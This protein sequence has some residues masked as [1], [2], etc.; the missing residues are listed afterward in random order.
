MKLNKAL[1]EGIVRY[2]HAASHSPPAVG[3]GWLRSGLMTDSGIAL[4]VSSEL[5]S[6]LWAHCKRLCRKYSDLLPPLQQS[7]DAIGFPSQQVSLTVSQLREN[8]LPFSVACCREGLVLGR[9]II[10][11]S[12][13]QPSY[14]RQGSVAQIFCLLRWCGV[15]FHCL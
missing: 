13:R 2:N 12:R 8:P 5:L 1:E 10:I 14:H 6:R 3:S 9:R 7:C 11:T 4:C 15:V